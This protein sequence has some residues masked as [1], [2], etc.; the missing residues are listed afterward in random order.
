MRS[1][2][3]ILFLAASL[4]GGASC[5]A[6]AQAGLQML[7]PYQM[8]GQEHADRKAR[9]ERLAGLRGIEAPEFYEYAMTP[10]EHGLAAYPTD[11]P[12]LRV[13]FREGV[14]FDFNKDTVK[15]EAAPVLDLIAAS[16]RLEPP[17]V[18]MF[19]AGH[20]DAIGGVDYNLGLGMRRA[21]AIA[22]A[23][24]LAGV[25]QAQLFA[26]S[27]GKAVPIAPNDTDDGR[28]Q[29]RR[30]EFLF[31]ARPEAIAAWLT[32]RQTAIACSDRHY[33]F[34][35]ECPTTVHV[36]AVSVAMKL[37]QPSVHIAPAVPASPVAVRNPRTDVAV[38][39]AETDV[40]VGEKVIDIDL[41]QKVF[42]M[43]APE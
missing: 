7:E 35:Q 32:R 9:L 24:A 11:I 42:R 12:V 37:V 40:T 22:R 8:V 23:L 10:S 30:V 25:N 21:R 39:P 31:G 43:R 16:L 27:F 36:V 14:L 29:N 19:V 3:A 1:R 38:Q 34:A 41:S 18:T 2:L 26:V 5:P 6:L 20:T 4:I 15:P 28:A 13:V 17:D 33:A